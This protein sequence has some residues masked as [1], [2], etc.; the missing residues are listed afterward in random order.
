[1]N[2]SEPARPARRHHA[3]RAPR[4][5]E[6]ITAPRVTVAWSPSNHEGTSGLALT[7][8]E[9]VAGPEALPN[10]T[11]T[12][13]EGLE[14]NWV[15]AISCA[16]CSEVVLTARLGNDP[17]AKH[18]VLEL[19]ELLTFRLSESRPRIRVLFLPTASSPTANAVRATAH[20]QAQ[21]EPASDP[22]PVLADGHLVD[23][24]RSARH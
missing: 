15:E 22:R 19:A 23:G 8:V 10:R 4:T 12:C 5:P 9:L 20:L 11:W 7:E 1:M 21:R 2:Q 3:R 6:R 16:R 14:S 18:L 17:S 24:K 13:P